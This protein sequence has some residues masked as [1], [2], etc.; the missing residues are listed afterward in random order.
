MAQQQ[1]WGFLFW[2]LFTA[3]KATGELL[4]AKDIQNAFCL[5]DEHVSLLVPHGQVAKSIRYLLHQCEA[6]GVEEEDEDPPPYG[7]PDAQILTDYWTMSETLGRDLTDPAV[8]W[9][10]DLIDAHD[11]A[12]K[13]MKF[14]EKKDTASQFRIRRRL[15]RK[16]S[17]AADGL[18]I[19]PA[20]SQLELIEEGDHL[21][22]CVGSYS[23]KHSS[24]KTAIFF[25]RRVTRPRE[26]YYTLQLN[27]KSLT[28]KQNRGL[29]NC[30]RTPEVQAFEDKWL[31]WVRAGAPR[32]K[33]GKP[34]IADTKKKG[35]A[36]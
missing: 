3:T 27:E 32:D 14:R 6:L 8:R 24:G 11:Q 35:A 23:T 10:K 4:T 13:L 31:A 5:G 30:A 15:L 22:H 21:H 17:F 7:V 34:I 19:R 12:S 29:R 36:A 16:W 20:A 26:P 2:E 1:D 18:F 25:I 9:P 28:V 33:S